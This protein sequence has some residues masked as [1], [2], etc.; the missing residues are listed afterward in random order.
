MTEKI[1]TDSMIDSMD[2][3]QKCIDR[4]EVLNTVG[5][6]MTLPNTHIATINQVAE[7]Y[8]VD[9]KTI[10]RKYK[11]NKEEFENDGVKIAGVKEIYAYI[12]SNPSNGT[13]VSTLSNIVS[14]RYG[15]EI[16]TE[17]KTVIKIGNVG[18]TVFSKRAILRIGMM[19]TGS[20]VAQEVR[21]QLLNMIEHT[22]EEKPELL[23]Y[24]IDKEKELLN[25]VAVAFASGDMM[26]FAEA[27]MNLNSFKDRHIKAVESRNA[28]LSAENSSL[29]GRN[30]TL[31][32]DNAILSGNILEWSNQASANRVVRLMAD[33]LGWSVGK[34]WYEIYKELEYKHGIYLGIRRGMSKSKKSLLSYLH[35]D[36]YESFYKTIAA[37]LHSRYVNP[38]KIFEKA[39]V[40]A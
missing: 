10:R 40:L 9:V 23:T 21:T 15:L 18:I 16:T 39:K 5:H 31:I 7:Y 1:T 25:D 36:E 32:G 12:T 8:E 35:Y 37:M 2:V 3:R 29:K 28:D 27:T 11:E 38:S 17:D 33:A 26:K 4:I 34:A 14:T 30:E 13:S 20:N 19:L 6:L 24:D 22:Q